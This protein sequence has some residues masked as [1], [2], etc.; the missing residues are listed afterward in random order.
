MTVLKDSQQYKGQMLGTNSKD[1]TELVRVTKDG[2]SIV[3]TLD[4]AGRNSFNDVFGGS[5]V[6]SRHHE[7]SVNFS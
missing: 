1:E 4:N 5:L 6:V 7:V 2:Y 3:D